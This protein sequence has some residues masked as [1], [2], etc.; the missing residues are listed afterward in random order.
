MV[1]RACRRPKSP[2][3]LSAAG[4]ASAADPVVAS[5]TTIGCSTGSADFGSPPDRRRRLPQLS[6]RRLL[7]PSRSLRTGSRMRTSRHE[8]FASGQK[9]MRPGTAITTTKSCG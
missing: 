6:R 5:C 3:A 4:S 7:I 1:T 8:D 2:S 9:R